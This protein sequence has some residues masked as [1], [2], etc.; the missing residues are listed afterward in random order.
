MK[1]PCPF[2][3]LPDMTDTESD[4]P[5][6]EIER[7]KAALAHK[8]REIE[9]LTKTSTRTK[10]VKD[11]LWSHDVYLR[12]RKRLLVG[13]TVVLGLL[14]ALGFATVAQLY[15]RSL[16]YVDGEMKESISSR[17][18]QRADD[19]VEAAGKNLDQR[20][21]GMMAK[22]GDKL[23]QQVDQQIGALI[24]EKK[25]EIDTLIK[26]TEKDVATIL[27]NQAQ[28]AKDNVRQLVKKTEQDIEAKI[29]EMEIAI[30]KDADAASLRVKEIRIAMLP[31]ADAKRVDTE[32]SQSC[33]P[34]NLTDG[35]IKRIGVRQESEGT[36]TIVRNGWEV[37]KNTFSLN[38]RRTNGT[39]ISAAEARCILD[40]VDRVVYG[41]DPDWYSP[42]KFVRIDR[43]NEFR[44]TIS[45]W[46]P[47]G[48]TAQIYLLGR[49]DPK[50][51]E[52]NLAMRVIADIDDKQYLGEAPPGEL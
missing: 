11:D 40:G 27:L 43:E 18:Q 20:V 24:E 16:N 23:D 28:I 36:G 37:F 15:E 30:R 47:T 42:S 31:Q 45:G 35:Q 2:V 13:V 49:R 14:G 33:D 10:E 39:A 5:Q 21:E 26:T 38:V 4:D 29:S 41:A 50:R 44:F 32:I 52:G 9:E 34:N 25:G 48:L 6:R 12:A 51:I 22:A 46:G 19:M 1:P 3:E 7:L 8:D 17:I